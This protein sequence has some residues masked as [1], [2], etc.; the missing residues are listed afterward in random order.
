[1]MKISFTTMATPDL[2]GVE[3]IKLAKKFGYGGVD[4]RVSDKKGELTE[5]STDSEIRQLKNTFDSEGIQPSGLFCYNLKAGYDNVTWQNM[6]DSI[7]RHMEIAYKLGSPSIRIFAGDPRDFDNQED[8]I[9]RTAEAINKALYKHDSG[10]IILVQNHRGGFTAMHSYKAITIA[11][12]PRFKLAF[13]PDH[14]LLESEDMTEVYSKVKEIAGQLYVSDMMKPAGSD[15]Y[16][17]VFPGEGAV[18]IEAAYKAIGGKNFEGWVTLK[19]EKL[20]HP[21]LEDAMTVLPRFVEYFKR[22]YDSL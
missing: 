13:S 4:L 11:D 7:L 22:I 21:E 19:W 5:R 3:A 2:D 16:Q 10:I 15:K 12:N 9:K 8:Y 20:W 18:D 17:T 1:M 6:I 14:C